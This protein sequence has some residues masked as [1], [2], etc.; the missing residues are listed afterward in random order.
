MHILRFTVRSVNISRK[1]ATFADSLI[2]NYNYNNL[3]ND[4]YSPTL[5]NE[6][7]RKLM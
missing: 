5:C 7:E 6:M 1:Q 4:I 3:V 2:L